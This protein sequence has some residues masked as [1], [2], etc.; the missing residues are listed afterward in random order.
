MEYACHEG[1]V[2]L[3]FTLSGARAKERKKRQSRMRTD[4]S[5]PEICRLARRRLMKRNLYC[6]CLMLVAMAMI[7]LR[8]AGERA[9][10]VCSRIRCGQACDID[11]HSYQDGVDQSSFVDLH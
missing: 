1:N 11:R 6:G 4:Q 2:D 3:E 5:G 8:S 9:S 10:F 7:Q